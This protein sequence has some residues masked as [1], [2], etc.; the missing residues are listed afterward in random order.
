[1]VLGLLRGTIGPK[2]DPGDDYRYR[3]KEQP[4]LPERGI[5]QGF[6]YELKLH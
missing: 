5:A 4:T 1:M 3:A 6:Q 2:G